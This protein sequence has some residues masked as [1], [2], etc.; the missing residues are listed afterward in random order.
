[1]SDG[2]ATAYTLPGE[3][4]LAIAYGDEARA[5]AEGGYGDYAFAHST[6]VNGAAAIAGDPTTGATGN[7]FDFASA[8]GNSSEAIAGNTNDLSP[9]TTGSSFDFASTRGGDGGLPDLEPS[10]VAIAG[11]NGSGDIATAVGQNV[12][13][14]AGVTTGATPANF[15]VAS[16]IAN[17]TALTT[18]PTEA[19]AGGAATALGGSTDVA[20]VADPSGIVGS[21]ADAGLG[22]NFDL[23]GVFGD[24]LNATATSANFM[25]D[26]LPSL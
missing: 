6:G 4:D 2:N 1:V 8:A 23:A 24:A 9:D 17:N 22:Y 15:D 25:V 3:Y 13:S 18:N 16:A 14:L 20:F 7:N 12:E 26:I 11:D 19:S 21:T 10:D 5:T